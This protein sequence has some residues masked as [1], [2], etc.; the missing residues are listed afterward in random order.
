MVFTSDRSSSGGLIS[1]AVDSVRSVSSLANSSILVR[2]QKVR[3][4]P[5]FEPTGLRGI[6]GTAII[7]I[8]RWISQCP[9]KGDVRRD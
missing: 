3:Q 9:S 7:S 4:K 1:R 2:Y 8:I 5:D 6:S